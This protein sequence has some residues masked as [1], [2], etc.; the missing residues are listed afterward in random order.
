[1]IK[2]I[3]C[4]GNDPEAPRLLRLEKWLYGFRSDATAYAKPHFIDINWEDYVWS[5]H[6]AIV[7]NWQP[8][9]AMVADYETPDRK[10]EMLAQVKDI[11]TAK[12]QPMVCPKFSG[13]AADIPTDCIIAVSV[14]TAYAGF[15][16]EPAEVAGRELHLLG[17]HPDQFVLL[18]RYY[19]KSEVIS[20]DCSAI[21]QKAQF[22]AFWSAK[23]NTWR[24]IKHR[25]STH[26]L[27]RMSCRTVRRY[28]NTPPRFFHKQ[29]QRLSAVGFE[30]RPRLI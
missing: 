21:F 19:S 22:G 29:R 20:I 9:I 11:R 8:E 23:R 6:L 16:P 24:Y 1:M 26:T 2:L 10:K 7:R 17:G 25:F 4:R 14:P 18:M 5:D 28:L 30:L 3:G 12:V 15:L 27:I 13:G